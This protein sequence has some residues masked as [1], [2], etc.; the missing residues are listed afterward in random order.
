MAFSIDLT[1]FATQV[2][3]L[4]FLLVVSE[5]L[6]L[7]PERYVRSNGI[8][9]FFFL[10]FK[11]VIDGYLRRRG[12]GDNTLANQEPNIGSVED[13]SRSIRL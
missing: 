2:G 5:V 11:R 8:L 13:P 1:N 7:V 9:H 4:L 10:L 12:I 6:A 3:A